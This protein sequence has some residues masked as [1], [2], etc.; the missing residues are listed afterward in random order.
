MVETVP[1]EEVYWKQGRST[2][3]DFIYTTT[4]HVTLEALDRIH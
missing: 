4:Q 3:K 1:R 2:E